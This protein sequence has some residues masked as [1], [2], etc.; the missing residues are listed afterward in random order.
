LVFSPDLSHF[1][2]TFP[3]M[4]LSILPLAYELAGRLGRAAPIIFGSYSART[5]LACTVTL[6]LLSFAICKKTLWRDPHTAFF[7]EDGAY[8]RHYS[9]FR[10]AE[11]RLF[12]EEAQAGSQ[13]SNANRTRAAPVICAAITTFKRDGVQ[14]LNDTVGSMLAGLSDEERS[15]LDVYVL[16]AHVDST[17]HPNWNAKWLDTVDHWAGYNVS[18]E[19]LKHIQ[20]LETTENF[21]EKGIL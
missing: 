1:T 7:R 5:V 11:A 19:Q 4:R 10:Q 9:I 18:E 20:E 14:Y 6:W 15:V 3:D 16:F 13:S 8:G 12:I 21:Y 17:V 2:G